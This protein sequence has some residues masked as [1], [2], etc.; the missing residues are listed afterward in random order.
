M[1]AILSRPQCVLINTMIMVTQGARTSAAM[2]LVGFSLHQYLAREGLILCLQSVTPSS[3]LNLV[4]IYRNLI[5][6]FWYV[7]TRIGVI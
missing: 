7:I 3:V 5:H 1:A 4:G 2:V 6:W